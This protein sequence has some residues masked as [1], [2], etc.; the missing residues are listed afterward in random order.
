MIDTEELPPPPTLDPALF[1]QLQHTLAEKGAI[2]AIDQLCASLR[3]MGDY[4]ALFYA[5]LMKK[6]VELGVSPFPTGSAS[7]LPSSTHDEYE[8]AIRDAGRLVGKLYLDEGDI[9]KAWFYF[10]MLSEPETVREYI[11]SYQFDP[12]Q[13]CQPV[14]EIALYQGVHPGKGFDLVL[15]RFGICNAITT[16]SGQD[17]SRLPEAKQ[18]CIARLVTALYNQLH[19]RL[20]TD[21]IAHGDP[22]ADDATLADLMQGHDYLFGEDAYHLDTSHLSSIAQM[23][24][25][26]SSG[27]ALRHARELCMYGERLSSHFRHDADPPFENTYADYRVLLEIFDGVTAEQG[28]THFRAK[29]EPALAEGNTF[30]AEVYISI[31]LRLGRQTEAVAAAKQ[32]L[33]TETRQLSCP[34]VYELCKDVGDFPGLAEAARKRADGVNFLAA[35]IKSR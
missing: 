24:L 6:R 30:P 26:L 9:R 25:E 13:D 2:P 3:E 1:E 31:L 4:Q 27:P 19:E 18:H 17:F 35:L 14:I 21:V 23:A 11:E 12:D 32:F 20:R 7:E 22:V 33:S 15:E 5:L 10:N 34:G 29:I 8:N 28:L 16:Y